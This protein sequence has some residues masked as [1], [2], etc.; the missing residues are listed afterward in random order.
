[1]ADSGGKGGLLA[2][3]RSGARHLTKRERNLYEGSVFSEPLMPKP[4]IHIR[5]IAR[6]FYLSEWWDE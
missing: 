5:H 2:E 4:R 6:T 3:G 1:M